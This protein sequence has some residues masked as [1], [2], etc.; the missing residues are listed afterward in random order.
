MAFQ[1]DSC[2]DLRR[3]GQSTRIERST[4][5]QVRARIALLREQ[6]KVT[7]EAKAFD[8]DRRLAEIKA[9]ED[10]AREEK[11]LLKKA[12][13]D[14]ARMEIVKDTVAQAD[15]DEMITLMGF[16]GFGSSKK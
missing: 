2:I 9:K 11:K 12:A 16:S 3:L 7:S 1:T 13:R 5:E 8:F 15:D 10:K 14:A 6:T 4:V